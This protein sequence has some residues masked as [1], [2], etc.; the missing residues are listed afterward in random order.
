[1][2]LI[3][4]GLASDVCPR[5]CIA[6]RL[7][8]SV[9]HMMSSLPRPSIFITISC[10]SESAYTAPLYYSCAM[11]W[12]LANK[13]A[14]VCCSI[15]DCLGFFHTR[16]SNKLQRPSLTVLPNRSFDEFSK[17]AKQ[18]C[19]F[20][21]V[22]QQSFQLLQDVSV[23]MRVELLLYGQSPAELHASLNRDIHEVVE[24]YSCSSKLAL[25]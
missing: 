4:I 22:V 25:L 24:I 3:A 21:D 12:M 6:C 11:G 7:C 2:R 16:G 5:I 23:E 15:C 19:C 13:K 8:N 20:C 10:S 9:L 18:G 14:E 1:M 17:S